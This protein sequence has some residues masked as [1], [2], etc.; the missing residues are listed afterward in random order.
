[1]STLQVTTLLGTSANLTSINAV[2]HQVT[3]ATALTG[4]SA[5]TQIQVNGAN[6]VVANTTSTLLTVGGTTTLT[7]NTTGITSVGTITSGSTVADSVGIIRPL[8]SMT[9]NSSTGI[10]NIDYTGIPSWVK[11][12]TVMFNG[13]SLSGSSN[14]L[15]QIGSGSITNTGYT[16]TGNYVQSPNL[17]GVA[18]STAGFLVYDANAASIFYGHILITNFTANTWVSTHM[19]MGSST[20][21]VMGGGNIALSG[22]LDR[23]RITTVNGTDT[24]DAGAV[25]IMY[26]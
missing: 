15:I 16:S 3:G 14:F 13:V 24:F 21:S 25:N 22:T 10:A 20:A 9:A 18:T 12:I 11:R 7:A 2:S 26:E 5:V 8:V 4:N 6:A 23:V 1:M 19:L 17:V